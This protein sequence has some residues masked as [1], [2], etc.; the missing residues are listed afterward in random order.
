M[1]PAAQNLPTPSSALAVVSSPA[2]SPPRQQ[3]A[4]ARTICLL[5]RAACEFC[6]VVC[7][8]CTERHRKSRLEDAVTATVVLLAVVLQWRLD[9]VVVLERNI[10]PDISP[11]IAPGNRTETAAETVRQK[12]PVSQQAWEISDTCC[13]RHSWCSRFLISSR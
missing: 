12:K 13:S 6:E 11:D 4:A 5:F 7:C 2:T 10:S 8:L 1:F 3:P 9:L